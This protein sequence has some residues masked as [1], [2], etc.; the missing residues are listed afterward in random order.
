M[1]HTPITRV[2]IEILELVHPLLDED[3]EE[4]E[5]EE[6]GMMDDLVPLLSIEVQTS[7]FRCAL[8]FRLHFM[9]SQE[10]WNDY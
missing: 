10:A 5:E 7:K 8:S 1:I 3:E 6:D 9:L 2:R 4:A